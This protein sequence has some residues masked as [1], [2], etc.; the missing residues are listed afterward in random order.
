[1][2][3]SVGEEEAEEEESE[4]AATGEGD[5]GGEGGGARKAA[6][7]RSWRPMVWEKTERSSRTPATLEG[8]ETAS[9]C[10]D[11]KGLGSQDIVGGGVGYLVF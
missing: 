7:P 5:E 6:T 10:G 1:M 8:L 9:Y 3:R 4:G 2:P 11:S